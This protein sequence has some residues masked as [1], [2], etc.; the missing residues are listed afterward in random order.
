MQF[1]LHNQ[2]KIEKETA[3]EAA[4]SPFL[5]LLSFHFRKKFGNNMAVSKSVALRNNHP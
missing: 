5:C 1:S 4:I 3:R 2:E